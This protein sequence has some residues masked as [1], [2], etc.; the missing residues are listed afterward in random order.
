MVSRDRGGEYVEAMRIAPH[1]VQVAD[2]F[3]FLKDLGN[4]VLQVFGPTGREPAWNTSDG[5]VGFRIGELHGGIAPAGTRLQDLHQRLDHR[6]IE[7]C[8]RMAL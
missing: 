6:R 7:L 3:H 8:S 5:D 2:R 4:A 1:A